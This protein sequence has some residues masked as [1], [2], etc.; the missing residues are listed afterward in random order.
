M[1]YL[2]YGG[3]ILLAYAIGSIPVGLILVRVVSGQDIRTIGSG[4]TGGTNALRA[5]GTV[6][7]I[8]TGLGDMAKGIAAVGMAR[9]IAPGLP[10][11]EALCGI[12]AVAG[13]NWSIYI[14]FKGGAGTGPNAGVATALWP[15]SALILIPVV[16][17]VLVITGYASVASTIAGLAIIAI[18]AIRATVL[19]TPAVYTGYAICTMFLTALALIPNYKRLI[20]GTE[21]LVGP[22]AR[23]QAQ[24][25]GGGHSS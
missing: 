12:A 15:I 24:R 6:T 17:F 4:R 23:M 1:D 16:P 8:L 5:A 10:L 21:R 14:N 7:G 25:S 13:H 22:R 2:K 9:W 11:M 20:A 18:F 3:A 19:G